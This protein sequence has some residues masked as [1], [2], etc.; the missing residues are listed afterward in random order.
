[1]IVRIP[2][3]SVITSDTP[4]EFVEFHVANGKELGML[5]EAHRVLSDASYQFGYKVVFEKL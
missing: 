1:M 3:E 2:K 5:K 4:T